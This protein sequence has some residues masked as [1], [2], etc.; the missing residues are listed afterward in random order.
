MS[1][2]APLLGDKQTPKVRAKMTRVTLEPVNLTVLAAALWCI[3]GQSELKRGT[4]G[5]V[6]A[7]PQASAVILDDLPAD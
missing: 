2:L 5:Y 4:A 6:R 7:C 3:V 1:A